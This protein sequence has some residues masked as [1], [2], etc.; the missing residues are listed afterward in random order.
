MT[1][2]GEAIAARRE[3]PLRRFIIRSTFLNIYSC[4]MFFRRRLLDRGLLTLNPSY[5]YAADMDLVLRLLERRIRTM[6]TPRF[7]ALFGYSGRNLTLHSK[8]QEETQIVIHAHGGSS[9]AFLRQ[10]ILAIRRCERLVKGYYRPTV[11]E[12]AFA[13]DEVPS[14]AWHRSD[15][16][17]GRFDMRRQARSLQ[18]VS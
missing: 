11:I 1:P 10:S 4:T 5:R 7:L 9:L 12:Y 2:T 8:M 3:I 6:H 15:N 13:T 17:S 18:C 16:L 14:Y